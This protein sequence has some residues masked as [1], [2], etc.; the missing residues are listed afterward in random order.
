V[1]PA[2]LALAASLVIRI[3]RPHPE[4]LWLDE[5]NTVLISL[6]PPAAI[7]EA[8]RSDGN[9]PLYYF[10]LHAWMAL[11]GDGEAAVRALSAVLGA[12]LAPA[13]YLAGA[14]FFGRAAGLTAAVLAC[15][16]PLHVYYS[17]QVRM[18][19]LLPVVAL[20]FVAALLAALG[21]GERAGVRSWG[22]VTATALAV[23]WTHNYGRFLVAS[24]PVAWLACGPRTRAAG[25]RLVL[26]LV[27]AGGVDLL[28]LPVVLRQASSGVGAWIPSF[29]EPA[30]AAV[31]SLLLFGAGYDHPYYLQALGGPSPVA[32]FSVAWFLL[33]VLGA[34]GLSLSDPALRQKAGALLALTLGPILV[35]Y[36]IS[37]VSTPIYLVGRYEAVAYPAFALFVGAGAQAAL[38][39]WPRAARA[40]SALALAAYAALATVA[41][42]RYFERPAQRV[43]DAL[44]RVV[45]EHAAAG[46]VVLTTGLARAPVEYY[47]RQLDAADRLRFLSH[48][49]EVAAHLGWY[50][51]AE[52][53]RDRDRLQRDA[54]RMLEGL[55]GFPGTVLLVHH[56]APGAPHGID[57]PLLSLL[58]VSSVSRRVLLQT[59]VAPGQ[60]PIYQVVAYRLRT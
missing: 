37:L 2:A 15:L 32:T 13:L 26:A 58:E 35:P 21:K 34:A 48:P 56:P 30:H 51:G 27:L 23:M 29:F 59:G 40:G 41:L 45:A 22:L 1:L 44:A 24:A 19:S 33:V 7:L 38:R 9:P 49:A 57:E 4:A 54:M 42:V 43:E 20:A 31:H 46:D 47:L 10:L 5:A 60:P 55:R 17:Q 12:L 39:S 16:W 52:M 14:R 50:D 18:Y 11:F 36:A 8:L 28:W 3:L 25:R 53:G 6:R